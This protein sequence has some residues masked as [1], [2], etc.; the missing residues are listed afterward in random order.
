M[1][2]IITEFSEREG[3]SSIDLM[4]DMLKNKQS[5]RQKPKREPGIIRKLDES[6]FKRIDAIEF[7][8]KYDDGKDPR[9]VLKADLVLVGISRTSKLHLVCI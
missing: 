2:D 1:C 6:Y 9:G 7:A 8:V 3:I 4:S 5:F